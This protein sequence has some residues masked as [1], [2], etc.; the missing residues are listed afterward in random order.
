METSFDYILPSNTSSTRYPNNTASHYTT[1][2]HNP[3]QLQGSWEVGVKSVFYNNRIGDQQEKA[4]V[5]VNYKKY[6]TIL[7][8]DVYPVG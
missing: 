8:N 7:V 1:V 3:L 4:T 6:N 2:P 5:K